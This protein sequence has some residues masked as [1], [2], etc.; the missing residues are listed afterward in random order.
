MWRPGNLASKAAVG[1]VDV[2]GQHE[3]DIGRWGSFRI[4]FGELGP[5]LAHNDR[6]L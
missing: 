3:V 5:L 2:T 6:T 1:H 4:L